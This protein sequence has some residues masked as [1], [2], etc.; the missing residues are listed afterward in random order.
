MAILEQDLRTT[1]HYLISEAN[2]YRS[3]G[4]G[5]IAAGSGKLKAG[6][7]L[8]FLKD[9]KEYVPFDPRDVP[10][11]GEN[12]PTAQD[13]G[14]QIAVAVLY[15]GCDATLTAIRR[16]LTERDSEVVEGALQWAEGLTDNHK[17]AALA[18]LAAAGII[19]R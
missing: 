12:P 11:V 19:A 8:G 14:R 6:A 2:G 15:E 1:A 4:V 16:T 10:G 3:R 7:V 18:S 9:T 17:A 5:V 13:D